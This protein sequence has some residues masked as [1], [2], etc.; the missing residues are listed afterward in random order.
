MNKIPKF[1]VGEE[2]IYIGKEY[3]GILNPGEVLKIKHLDGYDMSTHGY[4]GVDKIY[5]AEEADLVS[6]SESP[7][8]KALNES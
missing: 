7:L 6:L 4:Y 5:M 3:E 1:K 2:V 8:A